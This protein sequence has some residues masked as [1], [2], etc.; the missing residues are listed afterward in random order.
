MESSD[1]CF[2]ACS[3]VITDDDVG[4]DADAVVASAAAA[5]DADADAAEL[6]VTAVASAPPGLLLL[7]ASFVFEPVM[8]KRDNGR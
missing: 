5:A 6:F 8:A 4:A 2:C 1:F 3:G 7:F